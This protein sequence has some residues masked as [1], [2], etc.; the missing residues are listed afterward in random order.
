MTDLEEKKLTTMTEAELLALV[1]ER[2]KEATRITRNSVSYV[3]SVI[4][5]LSTSKETDEP[6]RQ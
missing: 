4:R 3:E 6:S 1:S 5:Q 2:V